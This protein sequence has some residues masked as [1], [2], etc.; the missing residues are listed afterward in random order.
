LERN[1]R[2]FSGFHVPAFRNISRRKIGRIFAA[3]GAIEV[4]TFSFGLAW[5]F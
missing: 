2:A 3:I 4:A 1:I 5:D